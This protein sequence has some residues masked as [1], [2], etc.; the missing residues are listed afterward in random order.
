MEVPQRPFATRLQTRQR[1]GVS[2]LP[3]IILYRLHI[4][5]AFC[6]AHLDHPE[7]RTHAKRRTTQRPQITMAPSA[8]STTVPETQSEDS[9]QKSLKISNEIEKKSPLQMISQGVCLP[10]IPTHPTFAKH[11]QWMLQHMA[12][13]FRVFA[14][15]GYTE[16]MSGHIS[17]RDP[18]HPHA[19]WTNPLGRH[20][21]LLKVSDMICVDYDGKPIGGNMSQ[22]ANGTS[23]CYNPCRGDVLKQ[24]PWLISLTLGSGGFLDPQCCTQGA[25]RRDCCL[26]C[27]LALRQ[28]LEHF[29]SSVGDDQPRC[30]VF[31]RRRA[32]RV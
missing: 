2:S 12:L 24:T 6:S 3:V 4:S 10:G 19:F 11:R 22:P 16:G 29:C 30:H 1:K 28:G 5:C 15:K 9:S 21:G 32:G 8:V 23:P 25:A 31:L 17:V 14:R 20:F 27:P 7:K 26:P 18:E 13:A